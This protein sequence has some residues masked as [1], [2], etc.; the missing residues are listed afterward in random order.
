MPPR[1]RLLASPPP[2]RRRCC[3]ALNKAGRPCGIASDSKALDASGRPA[4]APLLRG[5]ARCSFHA[6]WFCTLPLELAE[7]K[8]AP[9]LVYLDLETTGLSLASDEIVEIG[10]WADASRAAFSTVVKPADDSTA[11]DAGAVHGISLEELRDGPAFADAFRRVAAFLEKLVDA[12]L[13]DDESSGDEG[14]EPDGPPRLRSHAPSVLLAAHNGRRFDFG[15][16]LSQCYRCNVPVDA[17]DAWL[18]VDTLDVLRAA[19]D[20]SGACSKLQCQRIGR[21]LPAQAHA[22]RALDDCR[23]LASVMQSLAESLGQRPCE[24]LTRFAF[25]LD[26]VASAAELSSLL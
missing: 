18:Y 3:Q 11:K 9:L 17:L 1:R 21:R 8:T 12:A 26:L 5:G 4:A 2:C 15:M 25:K 10:L 6:R 14:A 24:L 16:L 22:H 20:D 19:A 7:L 23:T 13:S